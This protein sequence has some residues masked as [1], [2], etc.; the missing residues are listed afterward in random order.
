M[1]HARLPLESLAVL[2]VVNSL[3]FIFRA[4]GISYQEVAIAALAEDDGNYPVVARFAGWLS[5]LSALAM[6]AIVF[7]PLASVWFRTLSGLSAELTAFALTPAR[8]LVLLPALSVTLSLQRAILVHGRNTAPITWATALEIG[9]IV[10]ALWFGTAGLNLVGATAAAMAFIAGRVLC[11]LALIR[12]C[13][14]AARRLI[15]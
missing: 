5:G 9:G 10:A 15:L 11:N 12:P 6:A 4:V 13:R 7:T 8:I 2:P 1:G 3:S 14:S